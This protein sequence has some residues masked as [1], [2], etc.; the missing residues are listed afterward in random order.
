[1]PDPRIGL[2]GSDLLSL[3]PPL[4]TY[5]DLRVGGQLRLWHTRSGEPWEVTIAKLFTA[6]HSPQTAV[7]MVEPGSIIVQHGLSLE[8]QGIELLGEGEGVDA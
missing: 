1:M 4:H 7:F 6:P 5:R 2:S 8:A 3:D